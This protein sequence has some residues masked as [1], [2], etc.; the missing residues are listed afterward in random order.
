MDTTSHSLPGPRSW[1]PGRLLQ[2]YRRDPLTFLLGLANQHGDLV[3]FRFG[4]QTFFLLSCPNDIRDVLVTHQRQFSRSLFRKQETQL[5]KRLLG[6]GLLSSEGD[7]YSRNRRLVQ[8]AFHRQRLEAYG[9]VIATYGAMLSD[10]WQDGGQI[11]IA[12]EMMRLSLRIVGKILFD[13]DL[14]AEAK[15]LCEALETLMHASPRLVLPGAQLLLKLPLPRSRRLQNA[16]QCLDAAIYRIIRQRRADGSDHG[17]MLS[18]LLRAR[19]EAGDGGGLN[20]TQLRDHT[21]TILLAG[22]D[23]TANVLTWTWYLLSQNPDAE[24]RL[25]AELETFLA[26]RRPS[27]DDIT[28]LPY[29][30]KVWME[31]LRLYP[32][33]WVIGRR[34]LTDYRLADAVVPAGSTLLI[35]PYVVHRNRRYFS[36]PFAF[37]PQR[38]TPE[39]QAAL[40]PFAYFPFGGGPRQCIGKEFAHME[41]L[42]LIATL[43]QQWQ[44]RPLPGHPVEPQ[45]AMTL[46]CKH[47]LPVTLVKRPG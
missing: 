1:L 13:T 12:R 45:A 37:D 43:A 20:D 21:L 40:P 15:D 38:W 8:P 39:T 33:V 3:R 22:S 24:D 23:T 25:H 29:T 16:L 47:G 19:D 14:E 26:G 4:F 36:E 35:S 30:E 5:A 41:G 46:R 27:V 2:T 42:I 31:A 11:D 32:A 10:S 18:L 17:D 7:T 28:R 6:E 34:T 9:E 44:M